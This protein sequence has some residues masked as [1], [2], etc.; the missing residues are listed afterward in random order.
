MIGAKSIMA[1]I[2]KFKYL[3]SIKS[4]DDLKKIDKENIDEL[5]SEI[6]RCLIKTVGK[7]GGHLASNLGVVELCVAIHRV[8]DSPKDHII[9]DVGHQSYIHKL[10]TGR[11]EEFDTLRQGGGISGFTKRSESEHDAFGAGHSST[12]VSAA[13]GFAVADKLSGSDAYTV[14]VLGDGAFTGGMIHEALNNCDD[15]LKLIIILNENEMSISKNIGKFAQNMASTRSKRGYFKA[16]RVTANIIKGI[17]LIGKPMFKG[18]KKIKKSLKNAMYGSTYFED[19]GLYYL[20]PVDGNNYSHVEA[21]LE[22][23]KMA[24]GSVIIHIKTKKGKGFELAEKYPDLFHGISPNKDVVSIDGELVPTE[25]SFSSKMGEYLT[26]YA[27]N[28]KKV[29][30]ITAAMSGGTGLDA[31]A[32]AHPDRFFDVGIAEEHAV[33]FA[34]GLAANGYKPV[35]AVYSTFLQRAYDQLIHDVA[36]QKLPVV[37]CVDRAGL[38]AADG[39][40]HHGIFDI[41]FMSQIPDIKIYTPISY[42]GLFVS[43]EK[44]LADICPSAI[45]YPNGKENAELVSQF[46]KNDSDFENI[47]VKCN[48]NINERKKVIFVTH[49]HY[50]AEV[51]K[52]QKHLVENGIETGVVICE[53]IKPYSDVAAKIKDIVI[54]TE[55]E[56]CIFAEE[57]IK[58]G[59]FGMMLT[60]ELSEYGGLDN[61]K[62]DIV[63]TEG[64]TVQ[65]KDESIYQSAKISKEYIC[66][67]VYDMLANT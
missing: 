29:V 9:F 48:F 60:Y 62:I 42:K 43:M 54:N 17:P 13:L 51:I 4:P 8:F 1:D 36:L 19:M 7:N 2:Q 24:E 3:G 53:I 49:G 16:K 6:R 26:S 44:A 14:A 58:A 30:A 28:D 32:K 56:I 57:E 23:A 12:S 18:F 55:A 15:N 61:V 25:S 10:L 41:A 66:K 5:C 47:G 52:A 46:Y 38:N 22:E 35:F 45:R 64:F 27:Q 40:T 50:T 34:A 21:L 63:S 11:Y 67:K 65:G 37:F 20:G 31:F 33:T 59:G 39:P